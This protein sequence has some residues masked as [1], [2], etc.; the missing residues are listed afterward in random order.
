[1]VP[2]SFSKLVPTFVF[3]GSNFACYILYESPPPGGNVAYIV[4]AVG[5]CRNL[6]RHWYRRGDLAEINIE[7][8]P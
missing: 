6:K 8:P 1:M 4:V 5:M 2:Q 3:I 7:V